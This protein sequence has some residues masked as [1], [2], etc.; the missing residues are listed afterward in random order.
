METAKLPNGSECKPIRHSVS[1]ADV[2]RRSGLGL[3][4]NFEKLDRRMVLEL[5]EG[6]EG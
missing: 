6:I 5:R 2:V 4:G 3:L 1:N